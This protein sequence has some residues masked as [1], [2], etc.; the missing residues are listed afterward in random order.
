MVI[1]TLPATNATI[2][3]Y[4]FYVNLFHEHLLRIILPYTCGIF[5]RLSAEIT[6]ADTPAEH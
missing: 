3:A 6:K 1:L 4:T 5:H 2:T